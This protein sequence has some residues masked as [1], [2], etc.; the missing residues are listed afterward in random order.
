MKRSTSVRSWAPASPSSRTAVTSIQPQSAS[1]PGGHTGAAAELAFP[2][3]GRAAVPPGVVVQVE[4]EIGCGDR[5]DVAPGQHRP[6]GQGSGARV[7]PDV[8]GIVGVSWRASIVG[9]GIAD[10]GRRARDRRLRLPGHAGGCQPE[11]GAHR[12]SGDR[13]Q[14][15]DPCDHDRLQYHR[16]RQSVAKVPRRTGRRDRCR[17]GPLQGETR[18]HTGWVRPPWIEAQRRPLGDAAPVE[19]SGTFITGCQGAGRSG[20][21]ARRRLGLHPASIRLYR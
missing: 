16:S 20:H 8:D 13:E 14:P 5:G 7:E 11:A 17:A 1:G 2:H 3:P 21:G 15:P 19:C 12:Q 18:E 9:D 10:G 4:S 6:S